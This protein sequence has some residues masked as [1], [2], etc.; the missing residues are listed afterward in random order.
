MWVDGKKGKGLRIFV[1]GIPAVFAALL[2]VLTRDFG[3]RHGGFHCC[4]KQGLPPCFLCCDAA[5]SSTGG[6]L[7]VL[8]TFINMSAVE[9]LARHDFVVMDASPGEVPL[10]QSAAAS[11]RARARWKLLREAYML[12][13]ITRSPAVVFILSL[14]KVGSD[15]F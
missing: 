2:Q 8:Q 7:I 14:A 4:I 5:T 12:N 1:Q 13:K 6:K 10:R 11:V 3:L 15:R 9:R